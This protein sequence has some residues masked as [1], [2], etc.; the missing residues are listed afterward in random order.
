VIT[1]LALGCA[2]VAGMTLFAAGCARDESPEYFTS[3]TGVPLC[4]EAEV[5]NLNAPTDSTGVNYV[6]GIKADPSCR[7]E[8][9]DCIR[10]AQAKM[11]PNEQVIGDTWI[12]VVDEG[13]EL[14]VSYYT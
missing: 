7:E 14:I 11:R 13:E 6:V 8:L 1:K 10:R 5:R 3:V 9:L 2:A 12:E 4:E